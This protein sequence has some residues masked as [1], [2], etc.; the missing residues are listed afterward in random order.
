MLVACIA[1]GGCAQHDVRPKEAAVKISQTLG[2]PAAELA[3][4]GIS[5]EHNNPGIRPSENFYRFVNHG[6]L[7]NQKLPPNRATLGNFDVLTIQTE[8]DISCAPAANSRLSL[9]GYLET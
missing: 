2:C 6:W 3:G 4:G 9:D 7:V 1:A 5:L 8:Q